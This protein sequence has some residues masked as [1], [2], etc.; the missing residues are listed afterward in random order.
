M[1]SRSLLILSSSILCFSLAARAEIKPIIAHN[2]DDGGG[3]FQFKEVPAPARND[4]ASKVKFTLVDGEKDRNGG[5][6]SKLTDGRV[7]NEDDQPSQNFFFAAGVDGG[8]LAGDLGSVIDIKQIN[9]FS[10]HGGTRAPQ[11]YKLYASD[12]TQADFNAAPKK[13]TDPASCGWRL[14]ANID[15]RPKE[16]A[17]GGQYGVS[18]SDQAGIVGKYRYLLFDIFRTE[19]ADGFGNTFFSEIDVIDASAPVVAESNPAPAPIN[20]KSA[21]GKYLFVFDTSLSPDLTEWA[22]KE[23]GPVVQEWYPKIVEMFPSEGFTPPSRVYFGFREDMGGT[24]ASAG[25]NRVNIN[26][27]WFRQN[28]KG[29]GKGAVVHELV[30]VVQQYGAA[31]RTTANPT[32]TPGW[33]VEGIPDYVRWFLYEPQTRGAELNR[34]NIA[35]ARYDASYRVTGNFLDWVTGKYDKELT[36]KLNVAAREGRYTDEIWKELTSKSVQELAEE[37]KKANE[38]RL[39]AREAA[40]Q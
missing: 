16:G 1:N 11:V 9:T 18:I 20:L 34:R 4:A 30:H 28:L 2:Q 29:E 37:W 3:S 7:P 8:R 36:K 26:I 5:D 12:G 6:L 24:P 39:A 19:N 23:L 14:L 15:S 32:R 13:G 10:R 27:P 25:G 33:I 17:M 31:R 22:E 21:D 35:Q 40:K 38:E